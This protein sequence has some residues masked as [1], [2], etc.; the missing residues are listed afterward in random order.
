MYKDGNNEDGERTYTTNEMVLD[1][2]ILRISRNE[3][4]RGMGIRSWI[5]VKDRYRRRG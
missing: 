3:S 5:L 2:F 1:T 4:E